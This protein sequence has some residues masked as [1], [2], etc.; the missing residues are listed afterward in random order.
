M[1]VFIMIN[2]K[3]NDCRIPKNIHKCWIYCQDCFSFSQVHLI[4]WQLSVFYNESIIL[5]KGRS[6]CRQG[7]SVWIFLTPKGDG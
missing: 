7:I 4:K 2:D 1:S 6:I 3:N 5:Y